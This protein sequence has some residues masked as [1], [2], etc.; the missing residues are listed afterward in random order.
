MQKENWFKLYFYDMQEHVCGLFRL[1]KQTSQQITER[2]NVSQQHF[3]V[4][5]KKK[6][7][8]PC[9]TVDINN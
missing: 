9:L 3:S 8:T 1:R 6:K 7:S 4:F 2:V 5:E